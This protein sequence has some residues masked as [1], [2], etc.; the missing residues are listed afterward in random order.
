MAPLPGEDYFSIMSPSVDTPQVFRPRRVLAMIMGA[1]GLLWS[2][3][4]LYLFQFDGVPARTLLSAVFFVAFFGVSVAYYAR[5]AIFVDARGFTFRGILRTQRFAFTDIRKVQV[6]PGPVT[7]YAIRAR[8]RF[9]HFTSIF[10]HHR[11]LMEL[12]VERAGL[13]PNV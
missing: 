5:T 3:V 9:V 1:A 4:L 10:T 7:V 6:L 13:A 8:E 11:M 2:G 12:L